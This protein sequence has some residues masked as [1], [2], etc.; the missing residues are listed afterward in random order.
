[1]MRLRGGIVLSRPSGASR[2]KAFPRVGHSGL[3]WSARRFSRPVNPMHFRALDLEEGASPG[4]RGSSP[5]CRRLCERA[6]AS[7]DRP[8]QGKGD[9]S[10]RPAK[11]QNPPRHG[12]TGGGLYGGRPPPW[13]PGR[14]REHRHRRPPPRAV[15]TA[16]SLAKAQPQRWAFR[17]P[18]EP[19]LKIGDGG[20]G[21]MSQIQAGERDCPRG[22]SGA[23][24]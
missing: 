16:A 1:M 10:S 24:V 19:S 11:G 4:P 21:M 13:H 9:H 14:E 2:W 20:T 8:G 5:L 6:P 15:G 22:V 17:F 23:R 18:L 12:R 7:P 3:R